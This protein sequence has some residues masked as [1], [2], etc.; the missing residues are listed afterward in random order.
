[1]FYCCYFLSFSSSSFNERLE[2]R[3]LRTYHTDLH[4]IF[5][6]GKH[7]AVDFQPGICFAI[8]KGTLPW[9]PTLAAKSAEI[10][11]TRLSFIGLAFHNI[12]QDGKADGRINA[13]DVLSTSHKNMV[14]FGT[15]TLEFMTL[16]WQPF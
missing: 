9:Q 7:V 2:Q 11:D 8:A 15:L 3:D 10:G 6:V 16:I 4:Q 1:M 14:N 5:R 13:T 12:W